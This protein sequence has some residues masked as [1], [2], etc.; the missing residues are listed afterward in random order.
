MLTPPAGETW[1][2]LSQDPLDP[3]SARA[4]SVTPGSGAQVVFTGTVRDHADGRQGVTALEYEAY[5]EQVVEPLEAIAGQVRDR[6]PGVI[7]VALLH[8]VG[9]LALTDIAVVVA[10]SAG[11]RG[12][13]FEAARYAIDALKESVPIWKKEI[14]PGGEA[15]G[16]NA[17]PI[18][19]A[20]RRVAP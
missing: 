17:V 7:R 12:E 20:E 13:A 15:W 4:W 6:W 10:V 2:G 18:E 14:W 16:T 19:P 1:T 8:R 3:E 9:R 5:E 11:H